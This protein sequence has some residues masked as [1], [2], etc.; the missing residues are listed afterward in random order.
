MVGGR[1]IASKEG[2]K[3]ERMRTHLGI[4]AENSESQSVDVLM[5]V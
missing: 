4:W 3:E 5:G 2:W 1:S